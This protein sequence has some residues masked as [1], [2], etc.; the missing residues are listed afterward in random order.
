MAGQAG[1][2]TVAR[3][4]SP[5]GDPPTVTLALADQPLYHWSKSAGARINQC[6]AI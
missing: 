1:G 6:Q 3:R 5:H 2:A 4:S